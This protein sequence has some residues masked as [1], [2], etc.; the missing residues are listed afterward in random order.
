[1]LRGSL[2]RGNWWDQ[3]TYE[4]LANSANLKPIYRPLSDLLVFDHFVLL[5]L[6]SNMNHIENICIWYPCY[7]FCS[8]IYARSSWSISHLYENA[9]RKMSA[10]FAH[11]RPQIQGCDNFE[12]VFGVLHPFFN[13]CLRRFITGNEIWTHHNTQETEKESTQWVPLGE[14]TLS[15]I[16]LSGLSTSGHF[17]F[18]D[19]EKWFV[20]KTLGSND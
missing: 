3:R 1:M 9:I 12:Y 19:L 14:L 6:V 18:P 8:K 10:V 5:A 15:S 13:K 20:G 16:I 4:D 11:I 17:P 7:Q 2:Y